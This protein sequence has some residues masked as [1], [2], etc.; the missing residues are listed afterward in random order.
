MNHSE[1]ECRGRP[2]AD[3]LCQSDVSV[4][5]DG[6]V[7]G[8]GQPVISEPQFRE[9]VVTET[10]SID[11]LAR[12]LGAAGEL[13]A[14]VREDQWSNATPCPEFDARAQVGGA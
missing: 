14:G 9:E 3:V 12:A 7:G 8:T 13:I 6:A 2:A 11:G 10:A 5:G 1:V 4:C